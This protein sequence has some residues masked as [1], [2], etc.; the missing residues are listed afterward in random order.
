MDPVVISKLSALISHT[1]VVETNS[2]QNSDGLKSSLGWSSG[3]GTLPA[4]SSPQQS[5]TQ[6]RQRLTGHSCPGGILC[7]SCAKGLITKK[8]LAVCVNTGRYH[9]S[10]GEIDV[11]KICRDDRTF[12]E[13]RNRYFKIRGFRARARR[14]FLLRPKNVHFVKVFSSY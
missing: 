9:K 4:S 2:P 1:T 3:A 8:F 7:N 14:L 5:G 6:P 13:I 12:Q 10:L 11:S